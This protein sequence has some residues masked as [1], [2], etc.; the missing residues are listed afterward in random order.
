MV[1]EI[2][3]FFRYQMCVDKEVLVVVISDEGKFVVIYLFYSTLHCTYLLLDWVVD[4]YGG[5]VHYVLL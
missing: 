3:K 2:F 4:F 5:S 1:G